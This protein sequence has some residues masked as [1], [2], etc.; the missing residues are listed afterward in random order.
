MAVYVDAPTRKMKR[1]AGRPGFMLMAHMTADTIEELHAMAEAL[2]CKRDWY[3]G[4]PNKAHA[5]YDISKARWRRAVDE[6]G[7]RWVNSRVIAVRARA[8]GLE[9]ALR[10]PRGRY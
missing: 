8:L 3:Q 2:G 6:L 1:P 5:H 4:P 10:T 7:A 9:Q